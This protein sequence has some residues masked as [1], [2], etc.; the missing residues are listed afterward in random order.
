MFLILM[1]FDI[2]SS[3]SSK[4]DSKEKS[5]SPGGFSES[6]AAMTPKH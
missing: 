5:D 4:R 1:F 2:F 3:Y 6:F